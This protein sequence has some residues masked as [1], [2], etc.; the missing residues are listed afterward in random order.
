MGIFDRSQSTRTSRWKATSIAVVFVPILAVSPLISN[1]VDASD[2]NTCPQGASLNIVA[3]ADD[4]L[5]FMNPDIQ[6]DIDNNVCVRTVVVTAGD[7]GQG[8]DYAE[9][10]EAGSRAAYAEMAGVANEWTVDESFVVNGRNT[11]LFTLDQKPTISLAYLR[12]NDGN[13]NGEGFGTTNYASLEK[14]WDGRISEINSIDLIDEYKN[15]YSKQ[16]LITT[17]AEFIMLYAPETVR[18]M[19]FLTKPDDASDHSD[20]TALGHFTQRAERESVNSNQLIAYRGYATSGSA[21]NVSGT[22]LDSKWDSFIAY[23]V[24]DQYMCQTRSA[25]SVSGNPYGVW[26]QRQYKR[27]TRNIASLATPTVSSQNTAGGQGAAKAIDGQVL[28]YPVDST[29]EWA[30]LG[31]RENSWI[32]LTWKSRQTIDK[33]ILY[34]RPNTD[35]RITSGTLTFSDGSTVAVSGL[36]NKGTAKVIVFPAKNTKSLKFT[37]KTVSSST[38]NVGL[39]EIEVITTNIAGESSVT[40]SSQNTAGGQGAVKAIDGR[41]IGYPTDSTKEWA[42]VGGKANSWIKLSWVVQ[43]YATKITLFDRPNLSDQILSGDLIFS[44]GRV[45]KVGDLPNDGTPREVVLPGAYLTNS[46]QFKV[47]SVSATTS[48]IGL[49]EI[50]VHD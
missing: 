43:R 44:D 30:T 5:I 32:N 10:R 22:T 39:S 26:M 46:V 4:D 9:S 13:I 42:T 40:A 14:L 38:G 31:G 36:Y 23:A 29:K 20:H 35:D 19:D 27:G 17:L 2:I 11:W 47:T 41:A 16:E 28:G 34:D 25:C 3:H 1:R 15:T 24:Y 8:F 21:T 37:V 18:S 12:L 50:Q 45:V 48:N 6:R 7:A 49:A 33:V